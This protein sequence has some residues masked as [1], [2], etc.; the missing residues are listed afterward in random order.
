VWGD[1]KLKDPVQYTD[2]HKPIDAGLELS[3]RNPNGVDQISDIGTR[4]DM[5]RNENIA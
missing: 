3:P 5:S 1:R 2:I 4:D